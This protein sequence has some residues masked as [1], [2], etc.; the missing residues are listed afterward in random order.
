MLIIT[1]IRRVLSALLVLAVFT[2]TGPFILAGTQLPGTIQIVPK[3]QYFSGLDP[4]VLADKCAYM[5]SLITDA[6]MQPGVS[7]P[8]TPPGVAVSDSPGL[9]GASFGKGQPW[10]VIA[11]IWCG[12][13]GPLPPNSISDAGIVI[14]EIIHTAQ[15]LWP[16][17]SK[18]EL[19]ALDPTAGGNPALS[20]QTCF[21][22]TRND[23]RRYLQELVAHFGE[24]IY[25]T[26]AVTAQPAGPS[27]DAARISAQE[28][29]SSAN[30]WVSHYTSCLADRL[31]LLSQLINS[32][33]GQGG[34]PDWNQADAQQELSSLAQLATFLNGVQNVINTG[35]TTAGFN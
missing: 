12:S 5:D 32:T 28:R 11:K 2:E 8:N 29:V 7:V 17:L 25:Y 1:T 6:G 15:D 27:R 30:Y 31:F 34:A 9:G 35:L 20:A 22:S 19:D 21:V 24:L 10:G 13:V 23:A 16:S 18:A 3:E 4:N 26:S 33:G 14:H